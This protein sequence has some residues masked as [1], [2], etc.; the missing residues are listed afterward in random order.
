MP[1]TLSTCL[2]FS[3]YSSFFLSI[4]F[5]YLFFVC[6][7]GCLLF[8]FYF[9]I[10]SVHF[11]LFFA[12]IS[13]NV[14]LFANPPFSFK[15]LQT[16]FPKSPKT[17]QITH[18]N[19]PNL[20]KPSILIPPNLHKSPILIPPNLQK[21]PILIPPNLYKQSILIPPN[22]HKSP[23]LIPPNLHKP[24]ILIPLQDE[25]GT[26]AYKTVELD[27]FLDDKAVQHREVEGRES[28]LFLSY[29]SSITSA[30]PFNHFRV[31]T[32]YFF[33][34]VFMYVFVYRLLS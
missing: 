23:I 2:F 31:F 18:L 26:A 14:S 24:A 6:L 21:S 32:L 22:L 20:Y 15:L 1:A 17:P 9:S 10:V 19:P 8:C 5:V 27:N 28:D 11:H 13:L 7:L 4:F 25:Y 34:F 30:S 3:V 33:W 29:F 12:C 16:P